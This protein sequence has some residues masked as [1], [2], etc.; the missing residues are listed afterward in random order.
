MRKGVFFAVFTSSYTA[1]NAPTIKPAN[2]QMI[3]KGNIASNLYGSKSAY[4]V[5]APYD[6]AFIGALDLIK[7]EEEYE[8][9]LKEG[10]LK[11]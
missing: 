10:G 7:N 2:R 1:G 11:K 5:T 6:K 9:L 3:A 4:K 8:R